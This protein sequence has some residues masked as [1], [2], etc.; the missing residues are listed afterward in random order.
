MIRFKDDRM[1]NWKE[2]YAVK[3]Q[4]TGQPKSTMTALC[5]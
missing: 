2:Y 1:A 4:G 5:L 3:R